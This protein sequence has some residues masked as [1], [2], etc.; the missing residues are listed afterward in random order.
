LLLVVYE[1]GTSIG[2]VNQTIFPTKNLL[3][4]INDKIPLP[5]RSKVPRRFEIGD[6]IDPATLSIMHS[7]EVLRLEDQFNKSHQLTETEMVQVQ[8]HHA[9]TETETDSK[10]SKTVVGYSDSEGTEQF[11]NYF[12][13]Q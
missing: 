9:E 13:N 3:S 2:F 10:E 8:V 11:G 12:Y 7:E 4:F 1:T 6:S 5:R